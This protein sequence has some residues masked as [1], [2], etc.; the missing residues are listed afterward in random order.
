MK[1]YTM[2][3]WETIKAKNLQTEAEGKTLGA[4]LAILVG[5]LI[6]MIIR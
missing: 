2:R 4:A 3:E 1:N 6:L 5:L